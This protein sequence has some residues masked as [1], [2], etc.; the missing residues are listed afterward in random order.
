[1]DMLEAIFLGLLQG[2]T[3]F[4]PVSSS[5]HLVIAQHF[6][7]IRQPGVTFE[8][9]VHF[10]TL[11]SI[12]CVFRQDI[13][14]LSRSF[15]DGAEQKK[16]LAL[17]VIGTIPTG[18]MGFVLGSFFEK[19]FERPF[20]A[21]FMLLLTGLIVIIIHSVKIKTKDIR[22][23]TIWDAVI[24]GIF[25]GIA[26]IPGITRSGSTILGA[27]WR[28]LNMET[29]VRYSFL[30][31]LPAI[32]GATFY[33]LY[34]LFGLE[35]ATEFFPSTVSFTLLAMLAAFLS[36]IFAITIFI[37]LLKKGKFYYLAYYCWFIG[38]L[39]LFYTFY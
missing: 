6:L 21:G 28:G 14:N 7:G 35:G 26:I 9:M 36:G 12:I 34:K 20:I 17:L 22:S 30:M 37:N 2:L 11:L 3:E 4:L 39:T 19:T 29:A 1:M 27:L 24:I 16:F 31:A 10:G 8:V 38:I 15:W 18:F 25:Q 5:G 23:M 32:L 33:E 13:Y